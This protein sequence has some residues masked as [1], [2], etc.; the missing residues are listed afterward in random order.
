[1]GCGVWEA[2]LSEEAAVELVE[3][4]RFVDRL[5]LRPSVSG[6][7]LRVSDFGQCA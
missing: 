3:N 2:D 1:M 7:R 4:E 5:R 6:L